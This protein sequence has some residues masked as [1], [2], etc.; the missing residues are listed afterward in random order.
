MMDTLLLRP[1]PPTR[2]AALLVFTLVV[3]NLFYHGAQ[4]YSVGLIPAPWDKA[5][6]ATLF[7]GFATLTWV[8]LGGR[9]PFADLLAP[10]AAIVIGV[11][12]EWA[13]SFV[14]GRGVDASDLV[15]DA[16]GAVLAVGALATLRRRALLRSG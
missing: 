8:M 12:D 5:V 13:Q 1:S 3:F 7:A 14:P 9:S 11:A 15:A 6:H 16:I 10:I 2:L 4:P